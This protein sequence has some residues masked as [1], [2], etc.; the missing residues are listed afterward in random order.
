MG[1]SRF[2][3][4]FMRNTAFPTPSSRHSCMRHQAAL[5]TALLVGVAFA[6]SFTIGSQASR[7]AAPARTMAATSGAK[8]ISKSGFDISPM[9]SAE[10]DAAK[11]KLGSM[12]RHVNF[13]HGT[14]E[15]RDAMMTWK[16]LPGRFSSR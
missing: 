14:G 5:F 16:H 7:A 6:Y 10:L 2:I 9:T 15:P 3:L 4:A 8:T 11:A 1:P 13:E 12:E